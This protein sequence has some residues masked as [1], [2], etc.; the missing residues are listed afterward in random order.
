[1]IQLGAYEFR[2]IPEWHIVAPE[3]VIYRDGSVY[4]E[5]VDDTSAPAN[6]ATHRLRYGRMTEA[7]TER[8]IRDAEALPVTRP[9]PGV[10]ANDVYPLRLTS[11]PQTWD[12]EQPPTHQPFISYLEQLRSAVR[13]AAT[14]EWRPSRWV[15]LVD[16]DNACV[17]T[18]QP[19]IEPWNNIPVYPHLLE[20]YPLGERD[21]DGH[22]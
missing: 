17:V 8:L 21:C 4:T 13:T 9:N 5:T 18:E 22:P 7:Q 1:M 20:D 12:I 15:Q 19:G 3:L 11:G 2:T 14:E 10:S 16:G 6:N